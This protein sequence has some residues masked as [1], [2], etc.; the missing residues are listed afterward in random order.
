ML[1][2]PKPSTLHFRWRHKP[3]VRTW[4]PAR[5]EY[6]LTFISYTPWS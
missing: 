4:M 2:I 1:V 3:A 5:F 6:I